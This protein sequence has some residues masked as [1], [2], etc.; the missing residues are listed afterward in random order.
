MKTAAT[1]F[2]V[3]AVALAAPMLFAA[4][5]AAQSLERTITRIETPLPGVSVQLSSQRYSARDDFRGPSWRGLNEWRQTEREVHA[6]RRDAVHACRAA[7][8]QEGRRLGYRK[9]DI[10]DDLRVRQLGPTSFQV[11]FDEVE[12]E[13]RRRDIERRV[14]CETQRGRVTALH[15]LPRPAQGGPPGR[16]W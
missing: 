3:L 12:F 10:D 2:R 9:V 8:R 7:V 13:S 14:T 6:L 15:G 5:A 11:R 16:R 1:P 4:P